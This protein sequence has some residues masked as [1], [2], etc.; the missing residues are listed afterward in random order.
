MNSRYCNGIR[1]VIAAVFHQFTLYP[2]F[3]MSNII[4]FM[5]SYL[6]H[7]DKESSKDNTSSITQ[8]DG[9]FIHPIM[10]LSMSICCF[11]GGVVEHYLGPKLVILFG[12]I[13]IAL[14]DFLFNFSKNLILDFFINIFFGVGFGIA[15][16]AA[17]KNATKYFP[18][19]RGFINALAGGLG[20]N[21]GSSFFNL[22]IK[23]FVAKGDFPRT[24]NNDMYVISTAENY[25]IFFYIHGFLV[26]G[27]AIVSSFLLVTFN[28]KNNK[29]LDSKQNLIDENDEPTVK[30]N[31]D[32]EEK[33]KKE[34][35][36]QK[37]EKEEKE[38]IKNSDY[39]NKE[40]KELKNKNYKKGFKQ[41][42]KNYQ[43]Y[44]ILLIFL[45][46]SFLQGFIFTVGF[47]Y[48]TMTH[49]DNGE[50]K[51][52]P[53]EMSIIFT[54]NSLISS[55]M[56]PVFGL[57]Y[58]KIGFKYA[59]VIIDILS[60]INGITISFTV[61]A[62]VYFYAVSIILNG[63]LNS[64]AFSMIFPHVSKIFGFNYAGELYGFVVLST[65]VS[66]MISS[67]IYYTLSHFSEKKSDYSYSIIFITGAICNIIAGIL[68]FFVK[69]KTFEFS[70]INNNESGNDD[71]NDKNDK[72]I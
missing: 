69:F 55:A 43:I 1:S 22:V 29:D 23:L 65:G 66:C 2:L 26:L 21:L 9:Y 24:D 63:C 59:I 38:K 31:E 54:L 8:D 50:N 72:L 11:F 13:S 4:P 15:M 34:D 19:K 25:K 42:F 6:Y 17:V 52:S 14:G 64:G 5:I 62:G 58:D 51:I 33:D 44:I 56:G 71:T 48:G 53:D 41:I 45:F 3:M 39:D 57:I 28:D 46:T 37:E 20:G 27:V 70:K 60:A 67:S 40:E 32:K 12:G 7:I 47:N 16:T 10:S 36:E 30:G 49:N 18:K 61:K 35:N 68:A